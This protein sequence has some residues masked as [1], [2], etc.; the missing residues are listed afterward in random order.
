MVRHG[1]RPREIQSTL[2]SDFPGH[3]SVTR[4]ISNFIQTLR[5]EKL[6]GY[7]ATQAFV[8]KLTDN[9]LRHKVVFADE[10]HNRVEAVI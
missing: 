4:D 2:E 1:I 10:D 5:I 3:P 6:N 8:N 9:G 7:T